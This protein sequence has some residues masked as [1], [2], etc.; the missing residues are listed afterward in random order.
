[1]KSRYFSLPEHLQQYA[2]QGSQVPHALEL[3]LMDQRIFRSLR[4]GL[5]MIL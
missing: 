2:E 5:A 3:I 4:V 1:M